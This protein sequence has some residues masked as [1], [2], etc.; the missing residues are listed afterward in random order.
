MLLLSFVVPRALA[1]D[2]DTYDPAGSTMDGLGGLQVEAPGTGTPG[3]WYAGLQLVYA[4]NPVVVLDAAGGEAPWVTGMFATRLGGGYTIGQTARLDLDIPLYPMISAVD[5]GYEG[6]A[7]GD[8]RVG[9]L[10][11]VLRAESSPLVV[12]FKPFLS[13][14]TA[15]A[16]AYVGPGGFSAGLIASAGAKL[17]DQLE[18]TGNLGTRLAPAETAGEYSYGSTL[19]YGAGAQYLMSEQ[20][21]FGAE[22]DGVVG[23]ADGVGAYNKNPVELHAYGTFQHDAGLTATVGFG[24]GVVGGVGAPDFRIVTAVGWHHGSPPDKDK[25]GIAD[26]EDKCADRAEDVDGFKDA[27]GCPD[28]DNDGDNVSD[29]VDQCRD[30]AEDTDGWKDQDGCPEPDNDG[31]GLSDGEDDCPQDSGPESTGGCP[32]KDRDNLAD[33]DDQCPSEAGVTAAGGCPDKDS[34]SVP[35]KRDACPTEPKDPREDAARSD[36]CPK[37]VV[38]TAQRIELNE[39]IYFD[40]GKTTIKAVSF[41][42]LD[43]IAQTMNANAQVRKLEVGGHTDNEGD[44]RQNLALSQGRAEAVVKYLVKV[45]KVEASRLV[46]VGYGETRPID[47]NQ[48]A[49]GKSRNRRVELLIKD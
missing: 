5:A 16:G 41:P 24:S 4:A 49:D 3:D 17:G 29:A 9:G 34:D 23:L 21:R 37:R 25:D 32:D 26:K 35:D 1:L 28:A 18:I 39:S 42:L 6:F 47:T 44:D 13:L 15:T 12:G 10:L 11:P 46:A 19:D 8:V 7:F 43:E 14:P 48:T 30:V 2:A 36:G 20:W 31:D 40:S 38:V 33:R 45:G 22:L 27:D